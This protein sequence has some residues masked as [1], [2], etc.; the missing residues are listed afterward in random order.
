M[1]VQPDVPGRMEVVAPGGPDGPRCIV[2]F[3]HTP[4][5]VDAAL[6]ALRSSTEG[7]LI[8]VLGAGGDRDRG[9][10]P[11]MGAAAA[12]RADVVVVTDDNPRSED[13]AEIRAAVVEG[14][15]QVVRDG[16][17]RATEIIDGGTRAS[18]IAEAIA[19]AV[20]HSGDDR[21][22]DTVVVLGKGHEK[23]QEIH[24]VKHP[25]D[26]RDAV[27]AALAAATSSGVT[28]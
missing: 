18:A 16:G 28:A 23:G 6:S 11:A 10:R 1:A 20:V 4:D 9:K 22:V 15:Q 17:A 27:R 13:P 19:L 2:D 24:G 14:A 8:A 5:A 21:P 7:R 25:F 3:A 26:D 12:R